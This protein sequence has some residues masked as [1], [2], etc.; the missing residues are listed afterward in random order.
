MVK[1]YGLK[2]GRRVPAMIGL[3]AAAMF[4]V[5]TM[6]TEHKMLSLVFLALSYAGSDFMLP[7]SWAVCLDI[8]KKYAGAV[9]GTMNTAGQIGSFVTSL[10]FGYMVKWAQGN[11][12][13]LGLMP[14]FLT[15]AQAAYHVPLVPIAIMLA[16]SALLW[17]KV[18]PTEELIPE[19]A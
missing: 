5:L 2:I 11:P 9:T 19:H 1:K 7:I 10:T 15:P 4:T 6:I 8:G 13:V 16:V 18:D 17:L 14:S 3:G 12:D